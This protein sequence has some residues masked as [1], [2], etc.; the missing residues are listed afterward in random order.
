MKIDC[1]CTDPTHFIDVEYYDDDS[2]FYFTVVTT[3]SYW[4]IWKKIKFLFT[5]FSIHREVAIG[6]IILDQKSAAELA[7]FLTHNIT[8][9][10]INES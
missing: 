4:S 1:E 3:P 9:G 7:R 6:E 2:K 8:K 5:P 10:R